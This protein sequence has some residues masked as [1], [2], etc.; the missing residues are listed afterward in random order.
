[1]AKCGRGS[2]EVKYETNNGLSV[3]KWY[4]NRVVLRCSTYAE[5]YPV[6]KLQRHSKQKKDIL[7]GDRLVP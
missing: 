6:D 3:V 2:H 5:V 4:D 1:L 7:E